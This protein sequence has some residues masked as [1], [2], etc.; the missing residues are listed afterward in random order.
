MKKLLLITALAALTPAIYGA[1]SDRGEAIKKRGSEILALG[2]SFKDASDFQKIDLA[3]EVLGL[4]PGAN[5]KKT[6]YQLSKIYHPDRYIE[7]VDK[8]TAD[9]TF[10]IINNAYDAYKKLD[11]DPRFAVDYE[12]Y[13]EFKSNPQSGRFKSAKQPFY[14]QP[15][16]YGQQR[17]S[18]SGYYDYEEAEAAYQKWRRDNPQ[19][20]AQKRAQRER[21]ERASA[22]RRKQDEAW[23]KEFAEKQAAKQ[24]A[25]AKERAKQA[26]QKG[27]FSK[28]APEQWSQWKRGGFKTPLL[29]I[30]NLIDKNEMPN[31]RT[32]FNPTL[33]MSLQTLDLSGRKIASL[34]GLSDIPG[35]ESLEHLDLF[36][37][38]I[39]V[40]NSGDFSR[41]NSLKVLSIGGSNV[42]TLRKNAFEGLRN[43][44]VLDM[45]Y[46]YQITAESG[47]FNGLSSKLKQAIFSNALSQETKGL[48]IKEIRKISKKAEVSFL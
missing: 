27:A 48:I 18:R 28:M 39:I 31:I 41:L 20:E 7:Y 10:K 38:P 40:I 8:E 5:L 6:Y 42:L 32:H 24:R 36:S 45:L 17:E 19:T 9:E 37:N 47:A 2:A 43:L 16:S 46:E 33:E 35:I 12:A 13:K 11:D 34:E 4:K 30:Q 22:E 26:W 23:R 44:E 21:A 15:A 1:E 3:V 25:E 29:S 14:E